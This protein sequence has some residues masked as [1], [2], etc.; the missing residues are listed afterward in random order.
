MYK[1]I[2]IG[3]KKQ[4]MV[5]NALLPRLYRAHFGRDFILDMKKLQDACKNAIVKNSDGEDV[6]DFEKVNPETFDSMVFENICWIML[7]QG[8]NEVGNTVEEWLDTINFVELYKYMG[9]VNE[10]LSASRKTT[11]RP[12]KK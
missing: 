3:G 6:V 4:K 10:L 12:K 11:S 9:V 1:I 5:S 8:G 7:K 2:E